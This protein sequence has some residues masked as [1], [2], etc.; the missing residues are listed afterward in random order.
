VGRN[1]HTASRAATTPVS[2]PVLFC[3]AA[4]ARTASDRRQTSGLERLNKRTWGLASAGDC[5]TGKNP[6]SAAYENCTRLQL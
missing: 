2:V 3:G 1:T 6:Q 4:A 5:Q